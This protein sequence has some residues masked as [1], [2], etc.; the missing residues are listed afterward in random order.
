MA[1]VALLAREMWDNS[2][3]ISGQHIFDVSF[4]FELTFRW[5]ISRYAV[6]GRRRLPFVYE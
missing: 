5:Y 2:A 1:E 3:M 4:H 6:L